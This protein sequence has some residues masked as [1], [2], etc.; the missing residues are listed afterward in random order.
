[1]NVLKVIAFASCLVSG[2]VAEEKESIVANHYTLH[3]AIGESTDSEGDIVTVYSSKEG[4][5]SFTVK[6]M[7]DGS[8]CIVM[9]IDTPSYTC[10]YEDEDGDGFFDSGIRVDKKNGTSEKLAVKYT[11][12]PVVKEKSK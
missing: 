4:V 2:L 8:A 9:Q 11:A 3:Y 5:P 12:V 1:M 10:F 6:Y 7:P